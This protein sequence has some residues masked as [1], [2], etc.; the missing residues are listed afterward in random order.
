MLKILSRINETNHVKIN[1]LFTLEDLIITATPDDAEK[2]HINI[3]IS[4]KPDLIKSITDKV[5]VMQGNDIDSRW[6]LS[7]SCN[8]TSI[9]LSILTY[10]NDSLVAFNFALDS[11]A[12][13][14]NKS[15]FDV[16]TMLATDD[17]QKDLFLEE[18]LTETANYHI[19]SCTNEIDSIN[20]EISR[21]EARK[22]EFL[23]AVERVK[24]TC[25]D[26]AITNSLSSEDEDYFN[27]L[28]NKK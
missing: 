27:S 20:L 6:K 13:Q 25:M 14:Q 10:S 11:I 5:S 17:T 7:E 18:H 9:D 16:L 12:K 3:S 22:N 21:L 8:R 4:V 19:H 28:K 15:F 2:S 1:R 26:R 23:D 24:C